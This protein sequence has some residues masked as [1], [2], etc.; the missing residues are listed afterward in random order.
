ML[1]LLIL[2][3]LWI[4]APTFGQAQSP[5][6]EN[7]RYTYALV[8]VPLP[9]VLE[10]IIDETRLSLVYESDLVVGRTTFCKA[11]QVSPE[12]LLSC[13][14]QGTGLDYVQLSSGTYVLRRDVRTKPLYARLNGQ[15]V[16]AETGRPLAGASVLLAEGQSGTA[17]NEDGRFAF[18]Q[19]KPGPHRLVVTH[20]GY[21]DAADTVR[22]RPREHR[23]VDVPLR[24]R[25]MLAEPV[26]VNGFE[27]RLPSAELGHVTRTG[28]E[29]TSSPMVTPDVVRG[30]NAVTGVRLGD[31][32]SDVH[33]QGGASNEQQFLLDGV[34]VFM[35]VP[36]G[37]FISPFSPYAL[38]RVTVRKA[39]FGAEHGSHLSGVIGVEQ[40]VAPSEKHRLTAQVDPLSTTAQWGGRLGGSGSPAVSWMLTGRKDLW[41]TY[42]PDNLRVLFENW[43]TPDR[44]LLE[45]LRSPD[46]RPVRTDGNEHPV[47]NQLEVAFSDLHGA[48]RVEFGDL[49]SLHLSFYRGANAFGTES[50][51]GPGEPP[52]TDPDIQDAE[53]D[54][55]EEAYRWRNHTAQVRYE[56]VP[57]G[58]LFLN[59]RLWGSN[60]R[61]RHPTS[62]SADLDSS[63][64]ASRGFQSKSFN[65]IG[66]FGARMG[67]NLAT[68][69]GHD[70]SGAVEALRTGSDFALS[71]DPFGAASAQPE[72][73]RPVRWRLA[74]FLE[75]RFSLGA[76]TTLTLGTRLTYLP[77]HASVYGEP[78]LS[79]RY[80]RTLS[81][82]GT[83]AARGAVG[84]YRQYVHSFDVATYNVTSLLPRVRFW[85]P[86][87]RQQRPP[88]AYHATASVLYRPNSHWELSA[89]SYY[90]HQPHLLV[91]DY[92]GEPSAESAGDFLRSADGYAYGGAVTVSRMSER[93][94]AEVQYEYAIARRRVP[95]RFDGA[96]EPVPWSAPH[97]L[98]LSA[99]VVPFPHWTATL[100]WQGL[101]GR[102]WGF[103]QAY[104]DFLAPNPDTRRFPPFD[105]ST[106]AAHRLPALS[107]WDVGLAYSREIAGVSLQGRVTLINVFGRD[108]ISGWS[109]RYDE[110]EE[111]YVRERR[112][113]ASFI[114][115]VSLQVS[116]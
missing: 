27:A 8:G 19:I 39:G 56:W 44:F 30:L 17:T 31:A 42:Q 78:R 41:D 104:Y 37:G 99:D 108:N 87:G 55:F 114:P 65:E 93:L 67:G 96:F 22:V 34:P 54:V 58:Q 84:L 73:I 64:A 101:F 10:R 92:G 61:L 109:L 102:S 23:R 40:Q 81:S 60:Y 15:V 47:S 97:R 9:E 59:A 57:S 11:E 85:L 74:G 46:E 62:L 82:G 80:D 49:S 45:A 24:P 111:A 48:A 68:S 83:W 77:E 32:L 26:I 72:E 18:A 107:R 52:P 90:K 66:E 95:N 94:Q 14:L 63:S 105:L 12:Q 3:L 71:I 29:L 7:P 113:A 2:S 106:P 51:A 4:G 33:V 20:V 38:E 79:L 116:L 69:S 115:S 16:D 5:A 100:R 35:P 75:D 13:I 1:A 28:D 53:T 76:R 91:L 36:S 6:A 70:L 50:V 98:H 86:I 88:E 112:R 103:R 89:E 25:T 43:S 21:H 110:S